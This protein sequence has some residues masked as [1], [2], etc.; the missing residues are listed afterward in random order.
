MTVIYFPGIAYVSFDCE[1]DVVK[2]LGRNKNFIGGKRIFVNRY[3][4]ETVE[5]KNGEKPRP[6]ENKVG[7]HLGII[8]IVCHALTLCQTSPGFYESLVQVF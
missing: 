3:K 7:F 4:V 1:E 6:W 8:S 5:S 2:A